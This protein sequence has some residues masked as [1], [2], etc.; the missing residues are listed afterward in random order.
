MSTIDLSGHD[1]PYEVC[2]S[3]SRSVHFIDA[4]FID[5]GAGD[6][7]VKT[8]EELF[9]G[10]MFAASEHGDSFTPFGGDGDAANRLQ[11]PDH[12]LAVFGEL[13]DVRVDG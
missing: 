4:D 13:I 7:P 12:N 3:A 5:R 6:S 9:E 1:R 10:L 8:S 11:V 2:F